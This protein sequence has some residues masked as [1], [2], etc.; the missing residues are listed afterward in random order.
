MREQKL[1][2]RSQEFL[3]R[4]CCPSDLNL[5]FAGFE[6]LYFNSFLENKALYTGG[7][8]RYLD[9]YDTQPPSISSLRMEIKE[10]SLSA[11]HLLPEDEGSV[12]GI[13]NLR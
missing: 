6:S 12:C 7:I 8:A 1:L 10:P 5:D 9:M 2:H 3:F 4:F 11:K 13:H